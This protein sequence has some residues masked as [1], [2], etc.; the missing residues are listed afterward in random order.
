MSGGLNCL[1]AVGIG[2]FPFDR[3]I[4]RKRDAFPTIEVRKCQVISLT[5]RNDLHRIAVLIG[6]G[7]CLLLG[8][9]A[10]YTQIEGGASKAG[11]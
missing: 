9:R 4:G 5:C 6:E 11:G 7:F 10:I 8:S 1:G 3:P 2:C